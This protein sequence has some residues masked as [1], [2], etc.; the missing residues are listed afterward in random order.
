MHMCKSSK[1]QCT[2][3]FIFNILHNKTI[4][5]AIPVHICKYKQ[6]FTCKSVIEYCMSLECIFHKGQCCTDIPITDIE[7][8]FNIANPIQYCM[9][10]FQQILLECISLITVAV[11][12]QKQLTVNSSNNNT[13][14]CNSEE[15]NSMYLL[16]SL[17]AHEHVFLIKYLYLLLF[18][19]YC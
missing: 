10:I 3:Y 14:I 11:V 15:C 5:V 12:L 16:T 18:L 4:H 17:S 8:I 6:C 1:Q 9:P 2:Q 7:Y 13:V 19:S